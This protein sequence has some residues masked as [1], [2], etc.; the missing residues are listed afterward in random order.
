MGA[1]RGA[2]LACGFRGIRRSI[3]MLR[4]LCIDDKY[5]L[6]E[7][8]G[9]GGMGSVYRAV[10]LR[11][12]RKLAVKV[13]RHDIE[14]SPAAVDRLR[15]EALAVSR[16]RHPNIVSVVDFGVSADIGA[17]IVFE[18]LDGR[19]LASE[20]D[21]SGRM[22]ADEAIEL[23][24]PVCRAI[25][26]AHDAG[27]VH[28]DLKP[29]NLFVIEPPEGRTLKVLD[30][31]IS[32]LQGAHADDLA[33]NEGAVVG[34]PLSCRPRQCDGLAADHDPTSRARVRAL[35]DAHGAPSIRCGVRRW[36]PAAPA[37]PGG[38]STVLSCVRR[39]FL[40]R[41]R[42][43]AG[44]CQETGRPLSVGQ[45]A[46]RG[47]RNRQWERADPVGRSRSC[48]GLAARR[49]GAANESATGDERFRRSRA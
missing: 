3:H 8:L 2:T 26:A 5:R 46:R 29:A 13:L 27:V 17:F 20:L 21:E 11:L 6:E 14:S 1:E 30:F 34:T 7:L 24:L 44:A 15:R 35:R 42:V 23:L 37:Y 41:R 16:L 40:A 25:G 47:A 49:G 39:S 48:S 31:G 38:A 43:A 4:G 45:R 36:R 12:D 33:G 9:E 10:Q 22:S 32:T 18:Y 28:R 19:S